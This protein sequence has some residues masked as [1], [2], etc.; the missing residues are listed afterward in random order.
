[1]F[2]P[3]RELRRFA[4]CGVFATVV[5]AACDDSITQP[6]L[7]EDLVPSIHRGRLP[8]TFR[9][10]GVTNQGELVELDLEGGTAQLI[11]DAPPF[12]GRNL[13]WTGLSFGP[14]GQL[15]V[16]SRHRSEDPGDGCGGLFT[17]G[18]CSHLYVIDEGTGAV[19]DEVGSTGGAFISDIDFSRRG[20]L[21]GSKF[22]DERPSGD[23]G[24]IRIDPSDADMTV[25]GRFGPGVGGGLDNGGLSVHPRTGHLWGVDGTSLYRIKR[26]SGRASHVIRLGLNGHE[27]QFGLDGLEILPSGRFIG[28]RGQG[29]NELYEVNPAADGVSGLAELT[30]IPM[31]FD[32][33]IVGH[34]NSL[35]SRCGDCADA[36][37][38]LAATNAGELIEID[39]ALGTASLI[40]DVGVFE[41]RELGWTGLSVSRTGLLLLSSRQRSES[42]TDGCVGVHATGSCSHL[43]VVDPETG[44]VLHE[45]GSTGAAFIS[46]IDFAHNGR[47]F[48]SRFID[49]RESGDGGLVK[50]R[51]SSPLANL[52]GRFGPGLDVDL[53][54]GGLSSHPI[55]GHLWGVESS[56]SGVP[57]IFRINRRTG[58]ATHVTALGLDGV[59]APFGMDALEILPDGRFVAIRARGSSEMYVIDPKRSRESGFAEIRAIPLTL[60]AAITGSL[61]GLE[62]RRR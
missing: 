30:R 25:L 11:G 51:R 46:D 17:T 22:L 49:E 56:F 44:A 5:L 19:V 14:S 38:L 4:L 60:D 36:T 10:P 41:G 58:D 16:T 32:P 24:L 6:E 29:V 31:T 26:G 45:L 1:M 12:E 61:T 15:F 35:E 55:N 42:P 53:E 9:L 59:L 20:R 40:G 57:R 43:Y 23:G 47:L 48:G 7:P 62:A 13:G 33:A 54:N 21:F 39:L 52:V 37:V 34:V 3:S 28:T 27:A 18:P 8:G 50:W 2:E